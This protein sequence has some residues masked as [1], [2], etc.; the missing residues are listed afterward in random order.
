MSELTGC[1]GV[2]WAVSLMIVAFGNG[3]PALTIVQLHPVVLAILHFSTIFQGLGEQV[4]KEVVIRGIFESKVANV[5]QV[6]VE[7]I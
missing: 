5:A 4:T 6:L 2:V 7:L 1:S 3:F